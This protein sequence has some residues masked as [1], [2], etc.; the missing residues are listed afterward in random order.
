M[1]QTWRDKLS[2]ITEKPGFWPL[3]LFAASL[4]VYLPG[5]PRTVSFEDSAEFVAAAATLGLP[6]PSGFPL[7]VLLAGI[8]V[9]LPVLT[10]PWRVA[11]FSAVCAAAAVSL[12]FVVARRLVGALGVRT[13][14]LV[15]AAMFAVFLQL[16]VSEIWWSQAI[17]AKV[18]ALHALLLLAA[19]WALSRF[20][21]DTRGIRWLAAAAF[22]LGLAGS[23]HLFLT[24]AAAPFF[25]LAALAADRSLWRPSR[26]WLICSLALSA[27]L[28]PY[29]YL[30]LRSAG[31]PAYA[32]GE[33][34]GWGDFIAYVFRSRY[35]DLDLAAWK[36]AGLSFVLLGQLAAYL[37]PLPI[38]LAAV[39]AARAFRER[40]AAIVRTGLICCLG[41]VFSAPLALL[42]R[43]S[44]WTD[45][46][47]YMARVYGLAGY[48]FTAILAAVGAAWLLRHGLRSRRRSA[49]VGAIVLILFIPAATFIG[50]WPDLSPYRSGFVENYG[51]DLLERLPPDAVL[52]V[53]DYSFVQDTELFVLA[54]LQTVEA[55]RPDV[56]V[57][58]D[59]GIRCFRT[60]PL[61]GG[62]ADFPL[63][64]RRRLLLQAALADTDLAGRPLYATFPPEYVMKNISADSNG[65]VFRLTS[66]AASSATSV[67]AA[68]P[69][70]LPEMASLRRQP[71][72]GLLVSHVLYNYAA[73]LV[74]ERGNKAA[75]D[76]L[77]R[78][79]EL[80]TAPMSD[81]FR[82]FM[83]HRAV[84]APTRPR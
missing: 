42:A 50:N 79:I 62:Y 16:A 34:A 8:F 7:Y 1:P 56:T 74:E 22:L 83:A 66:P 14:G 43:A 71:A 10:I 46:S 17:Y 84:V 23:N 72:L 44:D 33:I 47:A 15:Q 19:A 78:A 48:P 68:P 35:G 36:R 41:G 32:M 6:H 30:P 26:R 9:W 55:L 52:V 60:P 18:Y 40:R 45:T 73:G 25:F 37:G 31:N 75:V 67:E 51:R 13:G 65:L 28:S 57:V 64:L 11:L 70:P 38:F 59:A 27:G 39:G 69:P 76:E 4:A 29:L 21:E 5:L 24:L 82:A 63:D 81:D 49:A 80:D 2:V 54:Y 3:A 77:V 58:Q 61:P 12:A 20:A 53:N